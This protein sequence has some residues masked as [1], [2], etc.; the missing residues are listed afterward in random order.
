MSP[1]FLMQGVFSKLSFSC[2][3][4]NET[5]G[6]N[7]CFLGMSFWFVFSIYR[8]VS[9]L[10]LFPFLKK[11]R[12]RWV[13]VFACGIFS[14]SMWYLVP[15]PGIKLRPPCTGNAVLATGPPGKPLLF[16]WVWMWVSHCFVLL[17]TY[18][19]ARFPSLLGGEWAGWDGVYNIPA[20]LLAM[21]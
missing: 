13:L 5:F 16:S 10:L 18:N 4:Y 17:V 20:L 21:C 14:Y 8:D 19:R 1:S 9:M 6:L 7:V 3:A 12:L 15:W 2:L 11:I